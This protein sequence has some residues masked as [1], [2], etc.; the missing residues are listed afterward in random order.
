MV[1]NVYNDGCGCGMSW[2]VMVGWRG[3][4]CGCVHVHVVDVVHVVH[5]V[6]VV[7]VVDV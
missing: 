3:C 7:D 5:V 6:D 1:C 4:M 2:Y